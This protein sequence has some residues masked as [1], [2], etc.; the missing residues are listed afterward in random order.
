MLRSVNKHLYY[1]ALANSESQEALETIANA[2]SQATGEEKEAAFNALASWKHFHVIYSLLDI[3]RASNDKTE[4]EKVTDAL[5]P[6][7]RNSQETGAIKYLYARETMQFAQNDQ[8]KNQ[9][10]QL[11]GTTGHYQA[12]LSWRCSWINRPRVKRPRSS[13]E[14]RDCQ[15]SS[16][17]E[18]RRPR[19]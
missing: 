13:H 4:L 3:A 8:Q 7:I 12:M 19:F 10:I 17:R 18:K 2:Y 9:L 14:H 16:T 1:S 6:I 11:M 15:P 5:I